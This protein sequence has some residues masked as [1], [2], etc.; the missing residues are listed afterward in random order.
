MGK[1]YI[2]ATKSFGE[3]IDTAIANSSGR[4]DGIYYSLADIRYDKRDSLEIPD[5][6]LLTEFP[7]YYLTVQNDYIESYEMTKENPNES[8]ATA[9]NNRLLCLSEQLDFSFI[10][11]LPLTPL[12]YASSRNEVLEM[13]QN[14]YDRYYND[15]YVMLPT[16]LINKIDTWEEVFWADIL[17]KTEEY[18]KEQPRNKVFLSLVIEPL[19]LNTKDF[20]DNVKNYINL[21]PSINSISITFINND[22]I[23]Y[24]A[25]EEYK[26]ILSL[27]RDLNAENIEVY[28]QYCGI[29]DIIF[30]VLDVHRFS[31]GWFGSYRNFDANNKRISEISGDSFA[32]R[33]KK[34]LSESIMSE[35]PLT[36]LEVLDQDKCQELFGINNSNLEIIN[37]PKLEQIYW[38]EM[39]KIIE[40]NDNLE[41]S[42]TGDELI[43]ERCSYMIGKLERAL[44][45]LRDIIE[46]LKDAARFNEGKSIENNNVK[47]VRMYL[48][49][50]KEFQARM[51][52]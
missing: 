11:K 49:V 2:N 39:L 3:K 8:G 4:I 32:R 28:I 40:K 14:F 12:S 23:N 51:F 6:D 33:A 13:V 26:N 42:Y 10:E 15:E 34:I 52:F 37:F 36:V 7:I 5:I 9:N 16:F 45:N 43:F 22:S 46:I 41:N 44:V 47:H 27:I 35:I 50:L 48:N 25:D 29:K 17:Q 21:C 38:E 18:L 24:Y 30:S 1:L 20:I 19:L 31:V